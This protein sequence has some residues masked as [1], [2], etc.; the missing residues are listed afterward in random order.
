MSDV[1]EIDINVN[2]SAINANEAALPCLVNALASSELEW[3]GQSK[4]L[5][6]NWPDF[7]EEYVNSYHIVSRDVIPPDGWSEGSLIDD[8]CHVFKLCDENVI[9]K[10]ADP[11]IDLQLCANHR[12]RPDECKPPYVLRSKSLPMKLGKARINRKQRK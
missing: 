4:D 7:Q 8:R 9:S 2:V 3:I 5:G 11:L 6:S 12:V 10:P 1:N